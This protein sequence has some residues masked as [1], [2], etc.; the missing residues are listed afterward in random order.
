[1]DGV[2]E[3]TEG[4]VGSEGGRREGSIMAFGAA[5]G[6]DGTVVGKE[7]RRVASEGGGGT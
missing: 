3:W 7:G 2:A 4:E 6:S 1:M 5:R